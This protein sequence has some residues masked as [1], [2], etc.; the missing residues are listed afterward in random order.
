M[1]ECERMRGGEGEKTIT[2][3]H[4]NIIW[5]STYVVF[6]VKLST[7]INKQFNHICMS[8]VRSMTKSCLMIL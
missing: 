8:S 2:K 6:I 5:F 3:R 7:R 4:H 1:G